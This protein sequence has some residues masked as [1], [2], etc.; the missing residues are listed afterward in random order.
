MGYFI[1][2]V[3][4]IIVDDESATEQIII[5][6]DPGSSCIEYNPSCPDDHAR[7]FLSIKTD[8]LEEI[9]KTARCRLSVSGVGHFFAGDVQY[10]VHVTLIKGEKVRHL[11]IYLG[12]DNWESGGR[13]NYAILNADELTTALDSA[14]S[15]ERVY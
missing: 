14:K 12:T 7:S 15:I 4:Q 9:L 5:K 1:Q 11:Q 3:N 6:L 2:E 10:R 13:F 8:E